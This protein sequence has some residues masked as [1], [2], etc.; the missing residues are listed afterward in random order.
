MACEPPERQDIDVLGRLHREDG[1]ALLC[2]DGWPLYRWHGVEIPSLV[3]EQSERITVPMIDKESNAEVR[4]VMIERY[5]EERFLR[6]GNAKAI[7]KD[8]KGQLFRRE[9][10]GD[11]PLVMVR[12]KDATVSK[13]GQRT[14]FLRVPPT[15][16]TPRQ[17]VAWTFEM[18]GAE[19][20]PLVE[21]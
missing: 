20:E 1:P 12:V 9:I 18:D 4:R 2:R 17:A 7:A 6:N 11:E 10:P 5:G 19:Y 16:E 8:E 13:D 15:I 14:Y 21:T 3:I